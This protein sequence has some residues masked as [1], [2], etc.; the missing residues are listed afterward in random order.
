MWKKLDKNKQEQQVE[1]FH[2][3]TLEDIFKNAIIDSNLVDNET[4]NKL[5]EYLVKNISQDHIIR[6]IQITKKK[7][8]KIPAALKAKVW[9]HWIGED[10]GRI[11]CLCCKN[12]WISQLSFNCGHIIPNQKEDNYQFQI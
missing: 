5:S 11:K 12:N 2:N 3:T 9:N 6:K 7:K 1:N 4:V 10:I 8:Q